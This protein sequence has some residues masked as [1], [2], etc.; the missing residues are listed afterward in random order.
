MT[1][2]VNV[3]NA[4]DRRW[5]RHSYLLWFGACAPTFVLAYADS[6]D[7]ALEAAAEWLAEHA[8]G[9]LMEWGGDD[10]I[11]LI[12]GVCDERGLEY[13]PEFFVGMIEPPWGSV[14]DAAEADLTYTESGFL[15][16]YEWG[17]VAEDMGPRAISAFQHDGDGDDDQD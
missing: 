14:L 2:K 11:D 13:R 4:S 12:R 17:I 3:A 15:T 16:S 10:H 5:R 9:H 8:P 1:R 6:L 7:D